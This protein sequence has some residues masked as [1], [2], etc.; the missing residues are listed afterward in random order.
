MMIGDFNCVLR[1]DERSLGVGVSSTF[2]DYVEHWGHIDLGFFGSLF[3]WHYGTSMETRRAAV[4]DIELADTSGDSY[5]L[6][7]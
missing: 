1:G 7:H 3:T 2:I 6:L 4:L 5:S